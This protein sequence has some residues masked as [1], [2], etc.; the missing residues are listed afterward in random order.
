MATAKNTVEQLQDYGQSPWLDYITRD[1]LRNGKLQE[2]IELVLM[3]MTRNPT[4]F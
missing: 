4:I 2:M 3:A 1:I